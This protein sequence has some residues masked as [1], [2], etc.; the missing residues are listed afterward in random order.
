MSPRHGLFIVVV[1]TAAGAMAA[2]AVGQ[3]GEA[4][5]DSSCNP[6]VMPGT[7][8]LHEVVMGVASAAPDYV[9]ACGYNPGHVVWFQTTPQQSGT[10]IFS[11]C[12]PATSYDTVLQAWRGTGDCEF[13]QRL[14]ALC[15]DDT[16]VTGCAN[17]CAY[18]GGT[19]SFVAEAGVT[20]LFQVS[21]YNN[22]ASGCVLCL[23]VRLY[24]CGGSGQTVAAITAPSDFACICGTTP[25]IGSA[26]E[27]NGLIES[28]QL[29]CRNTAGGG[30]T[31]IADVA[32]SP[33]IDGVLAQWDTS[34]L[35]QGYY[36]LRL[37]VT[38]VCG[39]VAV[40]ER[41]VWVDGQHD[42]MVLRAPSPGQIV[43][44]TVCLDGTAWDHCGGAY[45]LYYRPLSGSYVQIGS[46]EYSW[47]VNDPLGSW[48]TRSGVPDGQYELLGWA[49]DQCG[50]IGA[51]DS[52]VTVDNTAPIAVITS[53]P[54]CSFVSGTVSVIGT[55]ND[56]HLAG[57]T[58]QYTGGDAHGWVTIASGSEPVINNVLGNWNT[59][60]LNSCAYSLRL[61]AT[62]LAILDCNGALRNQTEYVTSVS[63]GT[64]CDLNGDGVADGDDIQ[65]FLTCL[66]LGV[67]P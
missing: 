44:G 46:T 24:L 56:A 30:W 25:I 14:D 53:P 35:P 62:D 19:L 5:T 63:I 60:G 52:I 65:L 7:P 41:V 59:T 26:Y 16:P 42:S 1:F 15:V 4:A 3:C 32:N 54:P 55:V 66:L 43:G 29:K 17:G 57:W 47:V 27:V 20:Y 40:A 45:E 38:N 18:Y 34:A 12:H 61:I 33:V 11:T 36:V 22:N 49:W 64:C 2:Q 6:R 13:P 31:V 48:N 39:Q 50:H 67:C 51:D 21:S 9:M 8:G 23:G 28:Y 37:T 58:L 10:L